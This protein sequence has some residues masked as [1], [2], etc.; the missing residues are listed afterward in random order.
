MAMA[1]FQDEI[2]TWDAFDDDHFEPIFT[3]SDGEEQFE[4]DAKVRTRGNF[5]DERH[6]SS[7]SHSSCMIPAPQNR[8][9]IHHSKG[10]QRR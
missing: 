7:R 5:S 2:S 4:G 8:T 9:W 1:S 3:D 6:R 10:G